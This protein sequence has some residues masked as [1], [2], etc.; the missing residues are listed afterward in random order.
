ML[1]NWI[2]VRVKPEARDRFLKAIEEDALAS[3]RDEPGCLR[4]NVL[5]ETQD[6]NVYYFYEVYKDADAVATHRTMPHFA[7]WQA[8][9]DCLDGPVERVATQTVFPADRAYWGKT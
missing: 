6:A 3:E 1:A 4:F 9:A 2:K 8:A 7:V 5:Q